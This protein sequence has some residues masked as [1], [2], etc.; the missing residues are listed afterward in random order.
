MACDSQASS[1]GTKAAL[2]GSK[3][4]EIAGALFGAEGSFG[5]AEFLRSDTWP[6]QPMASM[7]LEVVARSFV[8]AAWSW[9]KKRDA[10]RIVNG[11][12]EL[13]G[14]VLVARGPDWI[15]IDS[16]GSLIDLASDWW[17]IGSGAAEARGAMFVATLLEHAEAGNIARQGVHA[18]I[19]LDD[20]CSFPI[21]QH[22]T[23]P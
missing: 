18:A 13:S 21:N 15:L 22:W 4:I 12:P 1:N 8:A 6:R 7:P 19:A 10:L 17:A 2:R 9:L 5:V 16:G 23:L 11:S 3:I 14:N 20:G